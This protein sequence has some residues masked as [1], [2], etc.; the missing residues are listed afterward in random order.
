MGLEMPR[1]HHGAHTLTAQRA[2]SRGEKVRSLE[3]PVSEQLGVERRDD[4]TGAVLP[5]RVESLRPEWDVAVGAER[6]AGTGE[7]SVGEEVAEPGIGEMLLD[8]AASSL[9]GAI[10]ALRQPTPLR[11]DAEQTTVLV[12]AHRQ[13]QPDALVTGQERQVAVR[14]RRAH[15]L[16]AA[17]LLEPAKRRDQVLVDLAEQCLHAP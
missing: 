1:R 8:A 14:G 9:A 17:P 11:R 16:Q 6:A 5:L 10:G 12:L 15:D 7:V 2:I 4:D 3:P 13:L